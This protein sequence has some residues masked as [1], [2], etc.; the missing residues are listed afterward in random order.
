MDPGNGGRPI[1]GGA[2]GWLEDFLFAIAPYEPC[3]G[4]YRLS[5][6]VMHD[7]WVKVRSSWWRIVAL[8]LASVLI[9]GGFAYHFHLPTKDIV[10]VLLVI[11]AAVAL[12]RWTMPTY[13]WTRA[14]RS[15]YSEDDLGHVGEVKMDST[16]GA[17][18]LNDGE[19]K[20]REEE[21]DYIAVG[22]VPPG[23][24]L[25]PRPACPWRVALLLVLFGA[26]GI[27]LDYCLLG[28]AVRF[29]LAGAIFGGVV[30][31]VRF[32][33]KQYGVPEVIVASGEAL[34]VARDIGALYAAG[35]TGGRISKT[36]EFL[37]EPP[38]KLKKGES[39]EG[40]PDIYLVPCDPTASSTN[41]DGTIVYHTTGW[42]VYS[43]RPVSQQR[44]G[45]RTYAILVSTHEIKS[46]TV[47]QLNT[48][49]DFD[50]LPKDTIVRVPATDVARAALKVVAAANAV[51][52]WPIGVPWKKRAP[53]TFR[54]AH[55]KVRDDPKRQ[56]HQHGVDVTLR[57]LREAGAR[58]ALY[59]LIGVGLAF[60]CSAVVASWCGLGAGVLTACV[61]VVTLGL[62]LPRIMGASVD[63]LS[64]A[65][66]SVTVKY[67][68]G[69]LLAFYVAVIVTLVVASLLF[70]GV[71]SLGIASSC[72]LFA[73][74]SLVAVLVCGLL[75]V[76]AGIFGA[77]RS[78][79][80][81]TVGKN[82]GL[83]AQHT[84][85]VCVDAG[86]EAGQASKQNTKPILVGHAS[87]IAH[88][89]VQSCK[90]GNHVKCRR[91][92]P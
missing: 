86:K 54:K 82:Y 74:E 38:P 67:R 28:G 89:F 13:D 29:G 5:E 84:L 52:E 57:S 62:C 31:F 49:V 37:D 64:E 46:I 71:D 22:Y 50:V 39:W 90:V 88:C 41:K 61:C 83:A 3:F 60:F 80:V 43:K 51:K 48:L 36:L 73:G 14:A 75:A 44:A 58:A 53:T 65:K 42:K 40:K 63:M 1:G 45:N 26:L 20:E 8:L 68:R 12:F 55:Y 2:G 11:A 23:T 91:L 9:C 69:P 17:I 4:L 56:V 34:R 92:L 87:C 33:R 79:S 6:K 21:A 15:S 70:A 59:R 25:K 24:L 72:G 10:V 19:G 85:R 47:A 76:G 77:T 35:N 78:V 16:G 30:G 27:V 18:G 81:I 7:V 32:G 66:H